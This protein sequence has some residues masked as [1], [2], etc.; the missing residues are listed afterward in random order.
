MIEAIT[1]QPSVALFN[2]PTSTI[3]H[4]DKEGYEI[5]INEDLYSKSLERLP[6]IISGEAVEELFS[7]KNPNQ[8]TLDLLNNK[9]YYELPLLS[10]E[11]EILY[12]RALRFF[13]F[14]LDSKEGDKQLKKN[15]QARFDST[16]KKKIP[17]IP[18]FE[19]EEN[20]LFLQLLNKKV[21]LDINTNLRKEP[22]ENLY[23]I[24][25]CRDIPKEEKA[26]Y[27][28]GTKEAIYN[29]KTLIQFS[30]IRLVK[31][32]VLPIVKTLSAIKYLDDTFQE[33]LLSIKTYSIPK[34]NHTLGFRFSSYTFSWIRQ[35]SKRYLQ[36]NKQVIRISLPMS[37]KLNNIEKTLERLDL[38]TLSPKEK[39]DFL[40]E[41]GFSELEI[42][43]F[44]RFR[45][46]NTG[47]LD[48]TSKGKDGSENNL[49]NLA[50]KQE[51]TIPEI[52]EAK[53]EKTFLME[54]ILSS[55]L[56]KEE[57]AALY[58]KLGFLDNK[59]KSF[60]NVSSIITNGKKRYPAVSSSL[61]K[62]AETKIKKRWGNNEIHENT[63]KRIFHNESEVRTFIILHYWIPYTIKK[64]FTQSEKKDFLMK[65]I[66]PL[67][68]IYYGLNGRTAM[69]PPDT[70]EISL[71]LKIPEEEVSKKMSGIKKILKSTSIPNYIIPESPTYHG[72]LEGIRS[73]KISNQP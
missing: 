17:K 64:S 71:E 7:Q 51:K 5:K 45:N 2:L 73:E 37:E 35:A 24:L 38:Q 48:S 9:I 43:T 62:S 28:K 31:K 57:L 34:F 55:G 32:I 52:L 67:V 56:T 40:N 16:N 33:G 3:E 25:D 1:E 29:I 61:V 42:K 39:S 23:K 10:R 21:G 22:K 60:A 27:R 14:I 47:S 44:F 15:K 8:K 26:R 66:Y 46:H 13:E 53:E 18:F 4:K 50:I 69:K 20:I 63:Y 11:E 54:K 65:Q 12:F 30:N 36:N 19:P 58:L 49:Y 72:Y 70:K 6:S 41:E 59:G 68:E